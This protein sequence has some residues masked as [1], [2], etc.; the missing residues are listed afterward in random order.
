MPSAGARCKFD[1]TFAS[2][3][4]NFEC[5]SQ[6]TQRYVFCVQCIAPRTADPGMVDLDVSLNGVDFAASPQKFFYVYVAPRL[7]NLHP[8]Y[9]VDNFYHFYEPLPFYDDFPESYYSFYSYTSMETA[10]VRARGLACVA[11]R[12]ADALHALPPNGLVVTE[13]LG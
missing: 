12:A 8:Q 3:T 9:E 11:S 1:R 10:K 5:W 7:F 6:A 13:R 4:G 2:V